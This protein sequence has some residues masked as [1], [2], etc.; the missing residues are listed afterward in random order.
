MPLFKNIRVRIKLQPLLFFVDV[1]S[2][3]EQAPHQQESLRNSIFGR[4][5]SCYCARSAVPWIVLTCLRVVNYAIF[6]HMYDQ[7]CYSS[8]NPVNYYPHGTE[9]TCCRAHPWAILPPRLQGHQAPPSNDFSHERFCHCSEG[10]HCALHIS[11][12][13]Q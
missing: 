7:E 9:P 4:M 13:R 2:D 3:K 6:G 12:P 11:A 8:K 5:I 1:I 10:S